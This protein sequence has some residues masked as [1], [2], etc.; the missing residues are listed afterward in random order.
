MPVLSRWFIKTALI[1]LVF[2]L[3]AGLVLAARPVLD[4]PAFL[5]TLD[6][7]YVHL[8]TVGWLTQ[9]IFGVAF[10][11]FPRHSRERP[12]GD[13]RGVRLSYFLLNAGLL[14]RA[15]AEP[16]QAWRPASAWGWTL[17]A[18]A[19]LQWLAGVVLAVYLWKRVKQK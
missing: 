6:R 17:A 5:A 4:L 1:Y 13:E 11:L 18:S 2:A 14:L 9:L 19:L 10:W 16:L 7:T 3:V 15:G 12:Y 8:F